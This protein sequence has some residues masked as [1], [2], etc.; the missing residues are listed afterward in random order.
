MRHERD[1]QHELYSAALLPVDPSASVKTEALPN[2]CGVYF[3]DHP[4][5][6]DLPSG[7]EG[8]HRFVVWTGGNHE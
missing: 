2:R 6:C 1:D 4:G 5:S 8:D 3:V 7:H